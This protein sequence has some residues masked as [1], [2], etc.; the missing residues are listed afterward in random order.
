MPKE[1]CMVNLFEYFLFK[2]LSEFFLV[3]ELDEG[4][5]GSPKGVHLINQL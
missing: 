4:G 3:L 5:R 2:I 1:G